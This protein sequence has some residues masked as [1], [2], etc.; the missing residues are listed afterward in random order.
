MV[1]MADR[2]PGGSSLRWAHRFAVVSSGRIPDGNRRFWL[3]PV[4]SITIRCASME[5]VA[6][7][8]V[9]KV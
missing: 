6:E 7:K 9:L 2:W 8:S 3:I 1:G 5:S 4:L